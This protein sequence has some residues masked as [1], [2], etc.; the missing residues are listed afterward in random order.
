MRTP[1]TRCLPCSRSATFDLVA[2]MPGVSLTGTGSGQAGA[3]VAS[4]QLTANA[5]IPRAVLHV[6]STWISVS[7]SWC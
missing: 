5:A 2:W 3:H 1:V 7:I 6:S 4:L